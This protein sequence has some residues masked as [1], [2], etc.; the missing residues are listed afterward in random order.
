MKI[1]RREAFVAAVGAMFSKGLTEE[2]RR[3]VILRSRA[4]LR[5]PVGKPVSRGPLNMRESLII[6]GDPTAPK[7]KGII[8][9]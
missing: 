2:H 6:H 1:N 7:P 3:A 4:R 8:R 9:A 5:L